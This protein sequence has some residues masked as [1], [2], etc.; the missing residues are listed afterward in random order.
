[1]KKKFVMMLLSAMMVT[2]S[3]SIAH[4]TEIS[5]SSSG[6]TIDDEAINEEEVIDVS[7]EKLTVYGDS[8]I[9][10]RMDSLKHLFTMEYKNILK[11]E[12][13]TT[14]IKGYNFDPTK[15]TTQALHI[16]VTPDTNKS[17]DKC[18]LN[19][20]VGYP[21]GGGF[22]ENNYFTISSYYGGSSDLRIDEKYVDH[23]QRQYGFVKNTSSQGSAYGSVQ[24]DA[25]VDW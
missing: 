10:P 13:V 5:D 23:T 20:G 22:I 16:T 4:A 3:M 14:V 17:T 21:T 11:N 7:A 25:Y 12:R 2:G 8:G 18:R 15:I 19:V 6:V 24:F 1:M 9:A